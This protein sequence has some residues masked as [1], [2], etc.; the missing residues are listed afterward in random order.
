MPGFFISPGAAGRY[1]EYDP[2]NP[3]AFFCKS[4]MACG[5]N[6]SAMAKVLEEQIL[7]ERFRRGDDAAFDRIVE[8]HSTAVAALANRLLGWPGDVDDIV[9]DIFVA[10]FL[11]LKKFRG[12]CRLRTWLFTITVNKCRRCR[13]PW[14]RPPPI[15]NGEKT[16][17]LDRAGD[18]AAMDKETFARIR[19]VVQGLPPKYREV[20]VLRYLE[21]LEPREISG[22]LGITTNTV[23]VRLTRARK[24]LRERLGDL[25]EDR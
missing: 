17:G 7:V 10:A 13:F 9:Q 18:R 14:R 20:V 2:S 4:R 23:Q 15:F 16:D 3:L 11:G 5:S 25:L 21:E 8:Q 12:D 22:L 6:M 1:N 24:R 19:R